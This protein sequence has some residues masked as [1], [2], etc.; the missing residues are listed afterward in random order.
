MAETTQHMHGANEADFIEAF[1][2]CHAARYY[3]GII[4]ISVTRVHVDVN[5]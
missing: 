5:M 2:P 4:V 3:A 1:L